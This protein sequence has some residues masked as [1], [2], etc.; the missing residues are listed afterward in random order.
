[1]PCVDAPVRLLALARERLREG[2]WARAAY[3]AAA[4]HRQA[5][6]L[7]PGAP[8]EP[9]SAGALRSSL[10]EMRTLCDAT[11][12]LLANPSADLGGDGTLEAA[13]ALVDDGFVALGERVTRELGALLGPRAR[14]RD[15]LAEEGGRAAE[16]IA[17]LRPALGDPPPADPWGAATQLLWRTRVDEGLRRIAGEQTWLEPGTA[18]DSIFQPEKA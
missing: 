11:R 4:A 10:W 14:F 2:N 5:A 7:Q 13:V 15:A 12:A 17:E 16:R 3:L 1:M 6:P 18:D 9:A 8:A